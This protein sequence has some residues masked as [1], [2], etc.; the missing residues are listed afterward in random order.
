MGSMFVFRA[1][2]IIL[3]G[4]IP[5]VSKLL[6]MKGHNAVKPCRAC[7]IPAVPCQLERNV[8]YYV[9]MSHP[10]RLHVLTYEDLPLRDH[11]QVLDQLT[12]IEAASTQAQRKQLTREYGLNSRSIFAYL[13]SIDLATCAPYDAMHLLFENLIP[14]MIRHWI[15]KFKGLDQGS[16]TYQLRKEDWDLVGRLTVAVVRTIPSFFVGTLPDIAQ[17]ITLYKAEAYSFWF[18]YL[19][20]ILLNGLLREPYY[21]HLILM[22]DIMALCLQFEI[23]HADIDR[24]QIMVNNWVADY[25][26]LYYQYKQDRLPACPLTIHALLHLPTYIRQTGPLW[27]SWAFVMERFCGHL[28]PAVKNRTLPYQH[29]DNYVQRRAQMQIVSH[30]YSLPSLAK[31]RINYTYAGDEKISSHETVYPKFPDLVLGRPVN[32]NVQLDQDSLMNQLIKYFATTY[33]PRFS[34][35]ISARI[36]TKSLVRYG[37]LRLAGDGDRMRTASLIDK[38][39]TG[40]A[41][42]NSYIKYDLLP[43]RNTRFRYRDDEPFRRTYYGRLL[44]I[45]YVE[46][47]EQEEQEATETRPAIPCKVE[48]YILARVQECDTDGR[49]A[50]DPR[51]RL[52]KY[53]KLSTPDIIHASTISA[54]IGRV[55]CSDGQWAIVDRSSSG[56]RT[57]FVDDEGNEEY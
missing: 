1:F 56:A 19:A 40:T 6:M 9:P 26:R 37:R 14:N 53:T 22:R 45:Y 47:V 31:P 7:L 24:L 30:V 48:P 33:A 23:T 10:G 34:G 12:K 27:A 17:D 13:R 32:K 51:V 49:D 2:L 29:L 39:R 3:F 55:R 41:R 54:V 43:D 16:G 50:A 8:V 20:P 42:D 5:A 36:S 38:D 25:E 35:E 46:F 15:G 28:L 4:D 52:V 44:D 21:S 18:Q 57:Q 11:Q